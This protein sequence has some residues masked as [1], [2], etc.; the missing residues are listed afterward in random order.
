ME[1]AERQLRGIPGQFTTRAEDDGRMIIEGYFAVFDS[2][3][4]IWSDMSESIRQGAFTNTIAADDNEENRKYLLNIFIYFIVILLFNS[5]T[6]L[7]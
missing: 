6:F 5:F 2:V 4:Q 3:Y 7:W 1:R